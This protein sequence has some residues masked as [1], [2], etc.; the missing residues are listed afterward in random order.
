M[1]QNAETL[2]YILDRGSITDISAM[3]ELGIC[4]LG[5]RICDLR[6][7]G[8]AITTN[9]ESKVNRYGRKTS[10]G[11]YTIPYECKGYAQKVYEELKGRTKDAE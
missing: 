5:S 2:R 4:R 8:V 3:N 7:M 1:T 6:K 10:Y 9:Y 11:R